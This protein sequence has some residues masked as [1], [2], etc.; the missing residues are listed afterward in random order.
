VTSPLL[1][2][3]SE[4][5]ATLIGQANSPAL[6]GIKP[7]RMTVVEYGRTLASYSGDLVTGASLSRSITQAATLKVSFIDPARVMMASP[8]L[9]E[10][11][12]IDTGANPP[13]RFKLVQVNKAGD[14]ISGTYEDAVVAKLRAQ[15]GQL[16]AASG[17]TTRVQFAQ[18]LLR[19]AGIPAIVA[20]NTPKALVPLTRGTSNATDEDSWAC[21]VRIASDVG[22][23]CFSDGVSVWF[24]PDSWLLGYAPAMQI[25]E[26]SDAVDTID[27][28]HDIGKPVA[29]AK[30]ATY[31]ARWTAGLG[32]RVAARNLA[33]GS[34]DWIVS[35]ISRDLYREATAVSLVRSQP[36]LPEPAPTDTGTG[37]THTVSFQASN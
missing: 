9:N 26:Y 13:V 37:D 29:T 31:A 8:I 27:F 19:A 23:R 14:V 12:T 17:V 24:G 28:D 32:A 3:P 15:T 6:S 18:Q 35:E 16:A 4:A 2:G 10:A 34:G 30:V 25:G 21:L 1:P 36:T 11:V 7:E 22:Y 20:P 5:T 33:A